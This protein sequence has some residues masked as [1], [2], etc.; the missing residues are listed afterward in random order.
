MASEWKTAALVTASLVALFATGCSPHK[1][2]AEKLVTVGESEPVR[3]RVSID[4][5]KKEHLAGSDTRQTL[6]D[7]CR[8]DGR[9]DFVGISLSGG[10]TKAAV[11]G[12]ETL[13]Y[14]QALGLLRQT[15]V[16]SSVSGGSFAASYYSVS[17]DSNAD[18][19][20]SE[21]DPNDVHRPVWTHDTVLPDLGQGYG[22][23]VHQ[24]VA[25][26]F[27][28][29]FGGRVEQADFARYI[30]RHYFHS[31]DGRPF[32]FRDINPRRPHLFLNSTITSV[33]RVGLET[34]PD[35]PCRPIAQAGYLRRRNADEYFRRRSRF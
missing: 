13:F 18:G 31:P 21:P 27:S 35:P 2:V 30:D 10:G 12:A 19:V 16:V 23:L 8:D 25:R 24:G 34:S 3:W 1:I 14:L 32:R 26:L 29:I 17:C 33:D 5:M 15:A 20:C 28:P 9:R 7:R 22:D 11:F 4:C 6:A